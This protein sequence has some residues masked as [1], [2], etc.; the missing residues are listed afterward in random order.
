MA[1]PKKCSGGKIYRR[2]Y[3]S[4]SG[5]LVHAK[6][7]KKSKT[8]SGKKAKRSQSKSK[9]C[10]AGKVWRKGHKSASGKRIPGACVRKPSRK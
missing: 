4:K 5:K 1:S 3:R 8:K 7:V 10:G 9:R 6:C 2:S